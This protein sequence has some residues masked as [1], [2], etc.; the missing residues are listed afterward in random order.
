MPKNS[1]GKTTL[2]FSS[3]VKVSLKDNIGNKNKQIQMM[4]VE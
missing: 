3:S 1:I 4:P 2:S